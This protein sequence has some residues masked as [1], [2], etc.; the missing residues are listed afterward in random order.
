MKHIDSLRF[1]GLNDVLVEKYRWLPKDAKDFSEFLLPML[2]FD[3]SKRITAA[4]SLKS[5]FLA[6]V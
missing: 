1:W 2:E 4:E 5:L 6:D 3:P